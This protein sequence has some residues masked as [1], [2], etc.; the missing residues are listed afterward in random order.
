MQGFSLHAAMATGRWEFTDR[1]IAEPPI[2]AGGLTDPR[3]VAQAVSAIVNED[4]RWRLLFGFA[5]IVPLLI[6]LDDLVE[7]AEDTIERIAKRVGLSFDRERLRELIAIDKKY[8]TN[9]AEIA[10]IKNS[11][12]PTLARLAFQPKGSKAEA[13]GTR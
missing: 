12:A 7:R 5:G 13:A 4:T 1:T 6:T 8:D 11:V 9:A 2:P 3:R 10:S